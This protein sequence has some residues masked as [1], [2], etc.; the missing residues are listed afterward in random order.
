ML[1]VLHCQISLLVIV[2]KERYLLMT[3]NA[4]WRNISRKLYYGLIPGEVR[5]LAYQFAT[6]NGKMVLRL[7]KKFYEF[8]LV[9]TLIFRVPSHSSCD[10][11]AFSS[12]LLLHCDTEFHSTLRLAVFEPSL[13][14]FELFP[15]I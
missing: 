12:F 3:K 11:A 14:T 13:N 9:A 1:R 6:R 10:T 4:C 8:Q 7:W 2:S 5:T 15:E